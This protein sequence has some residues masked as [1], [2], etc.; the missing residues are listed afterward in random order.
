M[1]ESLSDSQFAASK[2]FHEIWTR[3]GEAEARRIFAAICEPTPRKMLAEIKNFK[4]LDLYDSMVDDNM[5]PDP[6]VQ[7]LA[8]LLA[9]EN[10]K[11]P[12]ADRHGPRGTTNPQTLDKHIRRLLAE[13]KTRL[14]FW[15][16]RPT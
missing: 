3:H 13:R 6:N 9:K 8:L 16:I 12:R 15:V 2:L 1:G 10:E 5:K 14:S 11:L 4:L 7:K